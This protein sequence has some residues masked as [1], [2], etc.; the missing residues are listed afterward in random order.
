M[1]D[2]EIREVL[3]GTLECVKTQISYV[4]NLQDSFSALW[5]AV[6]RVCPTASL[7]SAYREELQKIR[8]NAVQNAH[9]QTINALL[10]KLEESSRSV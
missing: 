3:I 9:I 6:A 8:P 4:R 5:D 7:E 2:P 10:A 1:N